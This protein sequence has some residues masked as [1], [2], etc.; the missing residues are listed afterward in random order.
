MSSTVTM[1]VSTLVLVLF[2]VGCVGLLFVILVTPE[3]PVQSQSVTEQQ[4]LHD[5]E[6]LMHIISTQNDTLYALKNAHQGHQGHHS[7]NAHQG[8]HSDQDTKHLFDVISSKDAEI[9]RLNE[10]LRLTQLALKD[11]PK[12]SEIIRTVEVA[13]AAPED[14]YKIFLDVPPS[15]MDDH[16]EPRFG[17]ELIENWRRAE[18]TWCETDPGEKIESTLTCYPYKQAHKSDKDMFCEATNFVIDF[19][20]VSGSHGSSK[21]PRGDQYLKFAKKSIL[22]SCKKTSKF[23]ARYFMPH[24][25]RQVSLFKICT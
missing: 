5:L 6:Q 7:K 21:P 24:S 12:S 23:N 25:A 8:H 22:S 13:A 17:L 14:N 18:Q 11:Q 9:I 20:K 19:S 16:C 1:K 2:S 10:Q 3:A 15:H 4:H